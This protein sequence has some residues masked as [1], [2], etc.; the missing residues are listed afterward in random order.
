MKFIFLGNMKGGEMPNARCVG[1]A[2]TKI[3]PLLKQQGH[4]QEK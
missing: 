4:I 2:T 3:P 1:L